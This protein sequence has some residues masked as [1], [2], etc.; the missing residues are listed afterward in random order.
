LRRAHPPPSGTILCIA[1]DDSTM[2]H[3]KA[4]L[5]KSGYIVL[6]TSSKE[7]GLSIIAICPCNIVLLD[8]EMQGINGYQVASEIKRARPELTFILLCGS[9]QPTH[10]L[11]LVDALVPKL[12]ASSELLATIGALCGRSDGWPQKRQTQARAR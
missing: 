1:D 12:D 3:E 6:T 11:A 9:T 5:R 7:Q 10:S 8:Y 2:R 4:L